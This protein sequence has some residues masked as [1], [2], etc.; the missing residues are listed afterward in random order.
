MTVF[1]VFKASS[2]SEKEEILFRAKKI[3]MRLP[4]AV[5]FVALFAPSAAGAPASLYAEGCSVSVAGSADLPGS[6]ADASFASLTAAFDA[7]SAAGG[8]A[9]LGPVELRVSGVCAPPRP[10]TAADGGGVRVVGAGAA[11]ALISGGVPV[12][13]SWLGPVT[14]ADVAAQLPP[15]ALPHVQQLDLAAHGLVGK[16]GMPQC[17]A[18]LGGEASILP[19]NLVSAGMELFA[20]GDPHAGGDASPLELARYPNRAVTP[21]SWSSG[22]ISNYT[23]FPDAATAAR[24]PAWARQLREDPGS[25]FVHYLGGLRWDDHA[26]R[27]ASVAAA[28]L[29]LAP[30][31]SH[32]AQPGFDSLD[33]KGTYYAYNVLAELDAPGEYY[34]NRTSGMLYVW[35][36]TPADDFWN[37]APWGAPVVDALAE[38]PVE[39]AWRAR[40]RAAPPGDAAVAVLS[41]NESVLSLAPGTSG[42]SFENLV[43]AFAQGAGVVAAGAADVAFRGVLLENAGSMALNVTGGSN[44]TV[45]DS[46]VRGAGSG[47]VFFYAGDRASL[48][49][50]GHALINVSVSYSNRYLYCYVPSVALADCGNAVRDC[51]LFGGPHQG[52]FISGNEHTLEGS[53]LHD[54]VQAASDSGAVYMGRDFTYRGNAIL[55]NRFHRINTADSGDD[56]SAVYLDDMVSGFRIEGNAFVNVSRALLLGGGRDNVFAS[57]SVD[58][59]VADGVHFDDR[60]LNW[61]AAA[62]TPPDGEMIKFLDRVPYKDALWTAKYPLLASILDDAPCMPRGNAITSNEYCRLQTPSFIDQTNATIASWGS[63]AWGNVNVT[64]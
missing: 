16:L 5:V 26:N 47:A 28:S 29:T 57:N 44:V 21:S 25:I 23:I 8:A 61:D 46:V 49:P 4:A 33:D 43:L 11:P 52:V 22:N 60:G 37:V 18:Y 6:L 32:Y 14:D 51:E 58:G 50:G 53:Y 12:P 35:L 62:C 19:G 42:L 27:L 54:L 59:T 39:A 1:C 56:V 34:V 24:L 9:M 10:L 31:P 45:A 63:T 38:R 40:L 30:C 7:V 15:A 17:H 20:Y 13:A 41:V 2:S 55:S 48:T 36:P 3:T 64:C